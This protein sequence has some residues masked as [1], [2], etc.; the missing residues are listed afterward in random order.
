MA[1][2]SGEAAEID[3][4][5]D[6]VPFFVSTAANV[7]Q[8]RRKKG[9]FRSTIVRRFWPEVKTAIW[10]R[11]SER[12]HYLID[13]VTSTDPD[14]RMPPK[15]PRLSKEEV[16]VLRSWIDQGLKWEA[17]FAFKKPAYEPPLFPRR[18]ELP[19]VVDGR[20]HPIDRILNAY[21]NQAGIARPM[22]IDDAVFVRRS[23]LDLIGPL[24]PTPDVAEFLKLDDRN[25]RRS[26]WIERLLADDI[27]YADHWMSFWNDLLRNDYSGTGFITGGRRQ[28]SSWLYRSLV[29]KQT[30]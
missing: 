19:P 20:E 8:G 11:W 7:I 29:D 5:H 21:W 25:N 28:I 12:Y 23:S 16:T 4:S 1:M 6:V 26:V 27:A 9:A 3:F 18:P 14:S 13:L 22:G 24:P 10:S 15:G 2:F 17:G 30:L